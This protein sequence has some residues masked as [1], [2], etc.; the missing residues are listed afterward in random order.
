VNDGVTPAKYIE[1]RE[2]VSG[3]DL[4]SAEFNGRTVVKERRLS[5]R[6]K[7]F[8]QGRVY[9]NNRRSCVDCLVRDYSE[10]GARL[11]FSESATV[12]D[13]VE[14]F[15][16]NREEMNRARVIWRS[17]NELGVSFG[18]DIQSPSIA[19]DSAQGDLPA[20]VQKLEGEVAALK[21]IVNDLRAA[22]R[23]QHGEVA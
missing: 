13:A 21:R 9:F 22:I 5:S 16:P 10:H 8:L 11:K 1:S 19:P 4:G 14:L 12:P 2:R 20:R 23:K 15:I 18:E 3:V 7:S 17:G 6:Q